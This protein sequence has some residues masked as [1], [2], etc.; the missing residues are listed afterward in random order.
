MKHTEHYQVKWH[1]TD[2]NR[3]V[4]PSQVL[5]YMQETANLQLKSH[6][7]PLDDLRD[8][9]GLGFI[10]SR[11]SV[12][13]YEPLYAHDEIDVQTWICESRGL[14]F[15][16]CFRILRSGTVIADAFSV[17]ALM[18]IRNRRLL[19][20]NEFEF[21]FSGDETLAVDLPRRVHFPVSLPV[22]EA[23]ERTIRYA[24]IDYNGHMNNTRYPDMLCDF[25][26]NVFSKRVMGFTLSYLH[27]ATYGHTLKVYRAETENGFLFRTV[28]GDGTVCL[29]AYMETEDRKDAKNV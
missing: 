12:R 14:S 3:E 23:G 10:L 6:G 29:E 7:I 9:H 21:G 25:L 11:I 4:R 16:R 18:D 24:D 28:D 1:D 26:P 17:W 5:M 8:R 22:E 2:A 20:V 27:E 13:I 15:N 19:K